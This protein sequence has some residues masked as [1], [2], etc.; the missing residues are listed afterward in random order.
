MVYHFSEQINGER[1]DIDT[2][3]R[4]VCVLTTEWFV[5]WEMHRAQE[6]AHT[7]I[8]NICVHISYTF[9]Y[10]YI[11]YIME[12]RYLRMEL[13]IFIQGVNK[14]KV[15][16]KIWFSIFLKK[17]TTRE[18]LETKKIWFSMVALLL[19]N[20]CQY[21]FCFCNLRRYDRNLWI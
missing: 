8:Q 21:Y 15:K 16:L 3:K 14:V 10:S 2:S 18:C 7:L 17:I 11:H 4:F 1:I 6:Y 13:W 12:L 19:T 20:F 5:K 9:A